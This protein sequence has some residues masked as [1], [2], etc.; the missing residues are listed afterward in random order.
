MKSSFFIGILTLTSLATVFGQDSAR[1][2]GDLRIGDP[3]PDFCLSLL[4]RENGKNQTLEES[5][6]LSNF[7]HRMPV[8]LIFGSYT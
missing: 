4:Q 6:T 8:V 1:R 3:A 5:V 2:E 7:F